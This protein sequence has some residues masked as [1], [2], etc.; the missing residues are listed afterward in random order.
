MTA[1]LIVNLMSLLSSNGKIINKR[2]M[3][4]NWWRRNHL[5]ARSSLKRN[6]K[7]EAA[8]KMM[9]HSLMTMD[10]M[11]TNLLKRKLKRNIPIRAELTA[12]SGSLKVKT[13]AKFNRTKAS[14]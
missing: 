11:M 7:R 9:T 1:A 5:R 14:I 8:M 10:Q 6:R 12:M 4:V 3:R 2:R 13:K